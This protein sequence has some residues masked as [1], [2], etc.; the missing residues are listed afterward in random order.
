[1]PHV[2]VAHP[3]EILAM[4]VVRARHVEDLPPVGNHPEALRIRCVTDSRV[5]ASIV[6]NDRRHVRVRGIVADYQREVLVRL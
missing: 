1:M 5:L 4:R 2:V 3:G 6:F